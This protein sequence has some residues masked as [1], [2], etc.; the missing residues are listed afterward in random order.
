MHKETAAEIARLKAELRTAKVEASEARAIVDGVRQ[1][2]A[3]ELARVREAYESDA[4]EA[5]AERRESL[6]DIRDNAEGAAADA[7]AHAA[8]EAARYA[9]ARERAERTVRDMSETLDAERVQLRLRLHVEQRV[10][11]DAAALLT[12]LS[13]ERH[14]GGGGAPPHLERRHLGALL[15]RRVARRLQLMVQLF[16]LLREAATRLHVRLK[17]RLEAA[18]LLLLCVDGLLGVARS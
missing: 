18:D 10:R 9:E 15:L 14:L 13:H 16:L 2:A 17:L 1:E 3:A 7:R 11:V 12:L 8:K 5:E 6:R 4:R